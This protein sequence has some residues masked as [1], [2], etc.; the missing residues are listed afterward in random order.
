MEMAMQ[1]RFILVAG[2][3]LLVGVAACVDLNED[4]IAGITPGSYGTQPVFEGMVNG[5]YSGLREFY[6]Q[7]RG[8]TVTEFGTDI[9]TKGSDGSHK[10][11]NDYTSQLN[12][13]DSYFRENWDFLYRGINNANSAIDQAPRAQ[14][15]TTLRAQRVGEAKFLRALY[16][17]DLVQMYGAVPL[18]L[19]ET[20]APST[21]A[22]RAPVDSVYDAITR[23]LLDAEAVLPATQIKDY[24]RA[25]RGAAQHLLAKVY[26]T[27]PRGADSLSN[28]TAK[29]AAGDFANAAVYAQKVINSGLYSLLPR[30]ADVF[31]FRNE[32]N[33]EVVWSIQYTADPLTTGN[34]NQGH[35]FFLMEYD[36]Q[37]GMMRDIANGR[38]YKRFRPTTYYLNMFDRTK[39][40][41][42]DAQFTR[43][44][45]ANNAA[46]IPKD[47]NGVPKYKVGDTAIVVLASNADTL[48]Y[49]GKPYLVI[50]PK[51]YTSKL[52]PSLN[53]FMDPNRSSVN[54]TRGSRDFIVMRLAETYLIAAE[55]LLRD[56]RAAEGLPYI[57]AVRTRAAIPGQ[58]AA[59]QLTLAQFTLTELLDERARELA[60]EMMRWFDLTRTWTLLYRGKLGNSDMKPNVQ[61]FHMLRP[62]PTTQIDRTSIPFPQNP[63]Y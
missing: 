26:L 9:Y 34:G 51:K 1:K 45:Y 29:K 18:S 40:S 59:M 38:P 7:E 12:A 62:I 49:I 42:Y 41:R 22:T 3:A 10:Y 19:H 30:F 31:D 36:A 44:W 61:Q 8:F 53:K 47:A 11:I 56:G 16:Y 5:A 28:E 20:T 27:R 55:A 54:E 57:N 17:F 58:E 15:D 37:P 23:D 32:R 33:K 43:V 4:V 35:L 46:T 2:G 13:G 21:V 25:T 60:G 39:D 24:G 50:P 48:Q 6:A 52:F 63:G 14:M